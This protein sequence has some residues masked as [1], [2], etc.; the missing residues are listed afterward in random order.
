MKFPFIVK[1]K[2]KVFQ[3]GESFYPLAVPTEEPYPN[4][5]W[6]K[7]LCP[8]VESCPV[9]DDFSNLKEVYSCPFAFQDGCPLFFLQFDEFA[10][11]ESLQ[12]VEIFEAGTD[13]TRDWTPEHLDQ[14][15]SN[16]KAKVVDPPLVALGHDEDQGILMNAGLPAAGWISDLKRVGSKL[17]AN[18]SDVP[19]KVA[20]AIRNKAY[21][22]ISAEIYP[23]FMSEGKNI[24]KVLRR[25]ALLGADIPRV[26]SLNEILARYDENQDK[27]KIESFSF[28]SGEDSKRSHKMDIEKLQADLEATKQEVQAKEDQIKK[29]AE[30][31]QKLKDQLKGAQSNEEI[32]KFSEEL[33]A[34]QDQVDQLKGKVAALETE[35]LAAMKA[36]HLREIDTFAEQLKSKGFNAGIL[37]E[38]GIK[39]FL[40]ALDNSKILEFSENDKQTPFQKACQ[41]FSE[42]ANKASEGK[43]FVPLGQ[44]K[45]PDISDVP[46]GVD[47]DAFELDQKIRKYAEDHKVSYEQAFKVVYKGGE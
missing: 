46:E 18:I 17:V 28:P 47:P 27:Q 2:R 43:L 29:F 37:D 7:S 8:H 42:I 33:K 40:S 22:Y 44:L 10:E 20:E 34:R 19:K 6:P 25:I 21:K 3:E 9:L 31:N 30:E 13:S 39:P 26:K 12:G 15:V 45:E 1:D 32:K 24:G 14:I 11:T 36:Q 23:F 38:G 4:L 41:I 5:P 16:F 35:R